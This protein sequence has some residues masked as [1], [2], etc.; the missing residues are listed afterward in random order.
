MM[1]QANYDGLAYRIRQI[2]DNQIV[3][4]SAQIDPPEKIA[5]LAELLFRHQDWWYTL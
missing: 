2:D 4:C 1:V 5:A 3:A